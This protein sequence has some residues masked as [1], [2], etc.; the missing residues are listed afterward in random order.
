MARSR[1]QKRRKDEGYVPK[2][3]R[4][5]LAEVE[6]GS[7][8]TASHTSDD[9]RARKRRRVANRRPEEEPVDTTT[10]QKPLP[11][12][13]P[14]IESESSAESD[15]GWEDVELGAH[16]DLEEELDTDGLDIVLDETE[17]KKARGNRPRNA[18]PNA[19][20]RKLRLNTHQ[21]HVLCLLAHVQL[22][23]RWCNDAELQVRPC[24]M[25]A[26]QKMSKRC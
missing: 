6:A 21:M 23:N 18:V 2:V 10:Q 3:Y 25:K 13:S 17:A 20:Q 1:G 14:V 15:V 26:Q 22:R 11:C 7:S 12:P 4:D 16:Q 8:A 9:S 5:L 24:N 19:A